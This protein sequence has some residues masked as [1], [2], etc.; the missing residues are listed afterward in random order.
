MDIR[1]IGVSPAPGPAITERNIS[2]GQSATPAQPAA[3]PVVAD[4][5]VRQ[6]SAVP[7]MEQLDEAVKAANKTVQSLSPNLEFSIDEDSEQVIVKIVDRQTKEIIRQVPSQEML[8]IAKALDR[9][10]GL[11][12]KQEA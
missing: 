4:T 9:V 2:T 1:P 7:K 11:L 3:A 12:I 10:K 6:P 8:E 5:T